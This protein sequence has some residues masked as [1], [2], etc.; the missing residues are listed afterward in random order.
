MV[1]AMWVIACVCVLDETFF[2]VAL[3]GVFGSVNYEHLQCANYCICAV[4]P[5][6]LGLG[7]GNWKKI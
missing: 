3:I 6:L 4:L 1:I 5:F 7:I 2:I